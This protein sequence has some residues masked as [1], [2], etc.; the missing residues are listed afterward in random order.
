M[1]VIEDYSE[2]VI[3]IN[4]LQKMLY[5]KVIKG[6]FKAAAGFATEM[7]VAAKALKQ[8]LLDME[9]SK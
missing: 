9:K 4:A 8:A 3:R 5:S 6:D 2:L 1:K 7:E